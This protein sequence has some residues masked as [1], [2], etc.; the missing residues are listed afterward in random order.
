MKFSTAIDRFLDHHRQQNHSTNTLASYERDLVGVLAHMADLLDVETEDVSRDTDRGR[1]AAPQIDIGQLDADLVERAFARYATR[2]N[3]KPFDRQPASTIRAQNTWS[4][5]F[6]HATER[7]WWDA[8]NPMRRVARPK[9]PANQPRALQFDRPTEDG[10]DEDTATILAVLAEAGVRPDHP[11]T[12]AWPARDQALVSLY[13]Y[14]GARLGEVLGSADWEPEHGV[15]PKGHEG[16]PTSG[17]RTVPPLLNGRVVGRTGDGGWVTFFGKGGK[18]RTMPMMP[19]TME[20]LGDYLRERDS[21]FG[22]AAAGRTRPMFLDVDGRPLGRQS[23]QQMLARWYRQAGVVAP[24]GALVHALRH[25]YAIRQLRNGAA[26][27]EVQAALGHASAVS[28]GVYTTVAGE[29]LQGMV[30]A[31]PAAKALERQRKRT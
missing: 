10:V 1:L 26:P 3:G 31:D 4:S 22:R 24:R 19:V 15:G 21:Q 2:R 28:T 20:L 7:G 13:A 9:P 29:S 6:D 25:S 16:A 23:F 11:R 30:A 5:L 17:H 27:N 8:A 12:R 14:T 18:E